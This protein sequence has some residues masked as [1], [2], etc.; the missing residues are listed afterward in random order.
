MNTEVDRFTL[1]EEQLEK[2]TDPATIRAA[3]AGLSPEELAE[4]GIV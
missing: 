3:L 2:A 4:C 1:A